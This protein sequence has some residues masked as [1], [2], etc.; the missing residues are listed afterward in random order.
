[1]PD[2]DAPDDEESGGGLAYDLAKWQ[3]DDQSDRFRAIHARLAVT[4]ALNSVVIGLFAI[5][6]ALLARDPAAPELALA[7]TA[8]I[9]FLASVGCTTI[10]L[11]MTRS[12]RGPT[13]KEVLEIERDAGEALARRWAAQEMSRAFHLNEPV[14]TAMQRWSRAA[15]LFAAADAAFAVATVLVVL[16]A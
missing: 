11:Q 3:L 15:Q 16:Y 8:L 9:I 12:Q 10:A 6:F 14:I 1:M 5:A 13:V 7:A 4:A 2:S